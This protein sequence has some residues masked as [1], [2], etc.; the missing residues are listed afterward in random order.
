MADAGPEGP[1]APGGQGNRSAPG[2]RGSL[3]FRPSSMPGPGRPGVVAL[4]LVRGLVVLS[5][6]GVSFLLVRVVAQRAGSASLSLL[7]EVDGAVPRPGLYAVEPGSTVA[8]VLA[9]AGAVDLDMTD[10]ALETR[11]VDG[12]LVTLGDDGTL[13]IGRAHEGVLLGIPLDLNQASASD[14]QAIPGIGPS[15]AS[16]IVA[17][18]EANGPFPDLDSLQ[19]VKGIGPATLERSRPF[20][21]LDSSMSGPT[22]GLA[23]ERE[24][25]GGAP[26]EN[27]STVLVV[28]LPLDVN[29]AT[30]SQLQALPGIGPVLAGAIV[31]ER[32]IGGP[33]TSRGDLQRVKGIGV[34]TAEGL[35]GLVVFGRGPEESGPREP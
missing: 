10:P 9:R 7:I 29:H 26:A 6:L 28:E 5:L 33:F 30:E 32:A 31:R 18:R 13:S 27:H 35:Q 19:R 21:A 16:A 22:P 2:G 4:R 14:L 24:A 25:T 1:R 15:T 23:Q 3:S 11:L 17:D 20:L 12:A 34:K 8:R